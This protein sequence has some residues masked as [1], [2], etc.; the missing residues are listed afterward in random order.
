[1]LDRLQ[2]GDADLGPADT[3]EDATRRFRRELIERELSRG[4]TLA[5]AAL[6][7]GLSEKALYRERLALGIAW[8]KRSNS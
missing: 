8:N 3:L 4:R 2:S 1:V 7:L 5:E 6:A